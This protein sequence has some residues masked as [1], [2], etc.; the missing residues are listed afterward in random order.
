MKERR[1]D[2]LIIEDASKPFEV[3]I[4]KRDIRDGV[5]KTPLTCPIAWAICRETGSDMVR[6]HL[7]R[8][9]VKRGRR[10]IRY[11]TPRA[12][13]DELIDFDKGKGFEPG[14]HTFR[15]FPESQ[16][17]GVPRGT[18]KGPLRPKGRPVAGIR[19]RAPKATKE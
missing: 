7:S 17:L 5:E 12:L 13:R 9:Y 15:P 14:V 16:L 1:I 4:T 6:V 19:M 3:N 8:T 18:G 2:G 11:E 10:Y